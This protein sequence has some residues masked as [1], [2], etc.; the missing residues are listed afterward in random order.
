MQPAQQL[1]GF[2]CCSGD[3]TKL[4]SSKRLTDFAAD[5]CLFGWFLCLSVCLFVRLFSGSERRRKKWPKG[6]RREI[7]SRARER[8]KKVNEPKFTFAAAGATFGCF[9][10]AHIIELSP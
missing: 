8:E 4:S 1:I 9:R 7:E 3:A 10:G 5:V 6:R 2:I